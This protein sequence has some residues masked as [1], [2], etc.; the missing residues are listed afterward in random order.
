MNLRKWI[1]V[2]ILSDAGRDEKFHQDDFKRP[3][4][5][6]EDTSAIM[7]VTPGA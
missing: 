5:P 7:P 2:F 1:L 4:L 3:T 6:K